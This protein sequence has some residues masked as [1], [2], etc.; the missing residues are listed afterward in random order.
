[1]SEGRRELVISNFSFIFFFSKTW[2]LF[3]CKAVKKKKKKQTLKC[4]CQ[5]CPAATH[6]P[7]GGSRSVRMRSPGRCSGW[8]CWRG[9]SGAPSTSCS[10]H[11]ESR[12]PRSPDP[13]R[14]P[15]RHG[16]PCSSADTVNQDDQGDTRCDTL[17]SDPSRIWGS[18]PDHHIY[19]SVQL[20]VP[21][22][23]FNG[24][25]H[26]LLSFSMQ[27]LPSSPQQPLLAAS[28]A[29]QLLIPHSPAV[30]VSVLMVDR[31]TG[32]LPLEFPKHWRLCQ[33]G[34]QQQTTQDVSV[35]EKGGGRRRTKLHFN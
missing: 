28:W 11:T 1:M 17:Q 32:D 9:G 20:F 16:P 24:C 5:D 21:S 27:L 30:H 19:R 6:S 4:R 13:C 35:G 26:V 22:A 15:S 34:A 3:Y 7:R 23:C 25:L 12:P 10:A 29:K 33:I 8:R 31:Q 18:F 2:G 14:R